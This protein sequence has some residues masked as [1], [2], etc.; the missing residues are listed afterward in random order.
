MENLVKLSTPEIEALLF[1]PSDDQHGNCPENA[2][3]V[4]FTRQPGVSL[5]FRFYLS[6]ADAPTLIYYPCGRGSLDLFN[7]LAASFTTIGVNVLLASWRGFGKS[8]GSPTI[9]ALFT[10]ALEFFS[11]SLDWLG[12]QGYNGKIFVMGQS[13]GTVAAIE[14]VHKNTDL[15]NGLILESS[16]CDTLP[17]LSAI[18]AQVPSAGI[19]EEEG[20]QNLR[21]IAAIKVPTIFFHGARDVLVPVSQAEKLQAASAAK[22]KQFLIIPGAEHFTISETGGKLYFQT[23]KGFIDTV[24]GVNTWRQRRRKY[25]EKRDGEGS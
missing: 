12:A 10:D 8:T 18:G 20:F 11:R 16:L 21:K 22:N 15:V 25:Q 2:K 6:A 23:I 17:F 14:V 3:D 4:L 7:P 13:L 24:C 5:A 9:S 1:T 19:A